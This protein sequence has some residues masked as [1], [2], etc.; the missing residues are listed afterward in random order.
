MKQQFTSIEDFTCR[1]FSLPQTA[2]VDSM[3][4]EDK[5]MDMVNNLHNLHLHTIEL[6]T[7]IFIGTHHQL[8]D[9]KAT[10]LDQLQHRRNV[11]LQK[12][13]ERLECDRGKER[14]VYE[15]YA[16]PYWIARHMIHANEVVLSWKDCYWWGKCTIGEPMQFTISIRE[17]YDR[18]SRL[19]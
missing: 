2:L 18:I 13:I 16:I 17:L 11:A 14:T 4:Y 1:Y 19:Q 10:I 5:H 12:D 7:G 15:W 6:S 3:L 9:K 8:M